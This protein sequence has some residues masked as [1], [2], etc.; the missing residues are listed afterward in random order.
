MGELQEKKKF[1]E[2]ESEAF[3]VQLEAIEEQI[4]F[5]SEALDSLAQI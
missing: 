1:L 3:S 4:R 2:K 5:I